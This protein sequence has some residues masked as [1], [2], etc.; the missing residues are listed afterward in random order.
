MSGRALTSRSRKVIGFVAL[1]LIATGLTAPTL[2][3]SAPA[4]PDRSDT[5]RVDLATVTEQ[6]DSGSATTVAQQANRRI[7]IADQRTPT[8]QAFALPDGT[9]VR[10]ETVSPQRARRADGTWGQVDT[11]LVAGTDGQLHTTASPVPTT[12]SG[13]GDDAPLMSFTNGAGHEISL[14]WPHQL[15]APTV[16]GNVATYTEVLP[17]VDLQLRADPDGPRKVFVIK[18]R[19]AAATLANIELTVQTKGVDL[20]VDGNHLVAD[21]AKTGRPAF[22]TPPLTMWDTAPGPERF[23][24][25]PG[26][27]WAPTTNGKSATVGVRFAGDKLVLTPD[28]RLLDDPT[29]HFPIRID[30]TWH[31][32]QQSFWLLLNS[33]APNSPHWNGGSRNGAEEGDVATGSTRENGSQFTIR[34]FLFFDTTWFAGKHILE[35][36]LQMT[37]SHAWSW[38][39]NEPNYPMDVHSVSGVN[40]NTT[41]NNQNVWGAAI[42]TVTITHG[43]KNGNANCRNDIDVVF[44]ITGKARDVAA[45]GLGQLDLGL[46]SRNEACVS[47]SGDIHCFGWRRYLDQGT[48]IDGGTP[49]RLSV[50]YNDPPATPGELTV[51]GKACNGGT[52]SIGAGTDHTVSAVLSDPNGDN[53]DGELQ[54]SRGGTA[55]H[56]QRTGYVASGTRASWVVGAG[57]FTDGQ[58]HR[59]TAMARDTEPRSSGWATG[60]SIEVDKTPPAA[61]AVASTDYPSGETQHGSVGKTGLFTVNTASSDVVGYRYGFVDPPTTEVATAGASVTLPLTPPRD[62]PVTLYVQAVDRVGN[63]SPVT[64]YLFGVRPATEPVGHW[65][66]DEGTGTT[67]ADTPYP[68]NPSDGNHGATTS[69]G[70]QWVADPVDAKLNHETYLRLDRTGT[71]T[72]AQPVVDTTRAFTVA[73]WVRLPATQTGNRTIVSQDGNRVSG[74]YLQ[75]QATNNRWQFMLPHADIDGPPVVVAAAAAPPR[76]NVWTHIA[77]VYDPMAQ[78]AYLYVDGV[79]A[80]TSPLVPAT[81]N[82]GGRL[83]IGLAKWNGGVSDS[84]AGDI[85]DVRAYDRAVQP[86]ELIRFVKRVEGWWGFHDGNSTTA[87]DRSGYGRNGTLQNGAGIVTGF[88]GHGAAFN[89]MYGQATAVNPGVRT[90]NSFTASAWVR[91][92]RGEQWQTAVSIDGSRIS[93][94]FL[95]YNADAK[96]WAFSLP[97]QDADAP[98]TT[99]RTLSTTAPK[100]GEWTHL[101]GVYDATTKTAQIWVNGVLENTS[102]VNAHWNATGTVAIG[103]ARYGGIPVGWWYGDI[104]E[105]MLHTGALNEH[106]INILADANRRV[107]AAQHLAGDFTGDGRADTVV[108]HGYPNKVVKLWALTNSGG[109]QLENPVEVWNSELAPWTMPTGWQHDGARWVAADFNGDGRSD[110]GVALRDDQPTGTLE[111]WSRNSEFW[112]L[113]ANGAGFDEPVQ[114]WDSGTDGAWPLD[115]LKVDAGDVTGDGKADLVLTREDTITEYRVFVLAATSSGL[116]PPAQWLHSPAGAADPRRATNDVGDI[117][118]DGKAD[119]VQLY[120]YDNNEVRMWVN[121]SDGTRFTGWA[122]HWHS[123]GPNTYSAART[124]MVVT[125]AT[126]DGKADV[127]HYYDN[128]ST[129]QVTVFRSNGRAAFSAPATWMNTSTCAPCADA[130]GDWAAIGVA[131]GDLDGDGP[132][133]LVALRTTADSKVIRIY[134]IRSTASTYEPPVLRYTSGPDGM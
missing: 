88:D 12:F 91:L 57:V 26:S 24:E 16:A 33:A 116:N 90:D 14:S 41:W 58:T 23:G 97:S 121:Y 51:N 50:H 83:N 63:L 2:V 69:G 20:R 47:Q 87:T 84:W 110:I 34:S 15:P 32:V 60:C 86:N 72:T 118:G 48:A 74:F 44:D 122:Q 120:Q 73:A 29:A 77:G 11:T 66:L 71:V 27:D 8:G 129:K 106:E 64:R 13:G 82:A 62:G 17:G 25:E 99:L 133:D 6:P 76:F 67:V 85:D 94:F 81:W 102:A 127:V 131:G 126:G 134:T 21:D 42:N 46:R 111:G 56:T 19:A 31:S 30:P 93:A 124:K 101:A 125:D 43:N 114:V 59:I 49:L 117:D 9:Y 119:L 35:A 61:P 70:T 112:V 109:G 95:Q 128:G 38:A 79:L 89:G 55:V 3:A 18:D 52:V 105:V 108:I 36:K 115:Y 39:C 28:R 22:V 96:R 80:G 123:G 40:G 53:V 10:E 103:R 68:T 130:A 98:A 37:M 65:K 5:P 104:D 45:A 107:P 1:A 78:R 100:L 75:Y 113:Y 54:I 7:E 4:G 132:D 92:N